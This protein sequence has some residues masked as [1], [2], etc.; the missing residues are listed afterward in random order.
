MNHLKYKYITMFSFAAKCL[1]LCCLLLNF[2]FW[3]SVKFSWYSDKLHLLCISNP[4]FSKFIG[5]SFG[6]PHEGKDSYFIFQFICDDSAYFSFLFHL[7]PFPFWRC[8]CSLILVLLITIFF[9]EAMVAILITKEIFVWLYKIR[10]WYIFPPSNYEK[11]LNSF[12]FN[13]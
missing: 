13:V 3:I 2:A 11:H 10:E 1:I 8:G 4:N 7:C 5:P 9:D 6:S 12:P